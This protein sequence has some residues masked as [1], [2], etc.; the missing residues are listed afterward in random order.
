LN[1]LD[2]LYLGK[3]IDHN[4]LSPD[5]ENLNSFSEKLVET[6]SFLKIKSDNQKENPFKSNQH[7]ENNEKSVKSKNSEKE[8]NFDLQMNNNENQDPNF[9]QIFP[10]NQEMIHSK[11]IILEEEKIISQKQIE[12]NKIN[13]LLEAEGFKKKSLKSPKKLQ[14]YGSMLDVGQKPKKEY[15]MK[16]PNNLRNLDLLFNDYK[17]IDPKK[18]IPL[19]NPI[20]KS[21]TEALELSEKKNEAQKNFIKNENIKSFYDFNRYESFLNEVT[22]KNSSMQNLPPDS[23]K[24]PSS[25]EDF[26]LKFSHLKNELETLSQKIN[27]VVVP[28]PQENQEKEENS[29]ENQDDLLIASLKNLEEDNEKPK[30]YE[31]I[32]QSNQDLNKKQKSNNDRD[33]R[34]PTQR[35]NKGHENENM[36]YSLR[37]LNMR[38][39]EKEKYE[40]TFSLQESSFLKNMNHEREEKSKFQADIHEFERNKQ[41]N[42]KLFIVHGLIESFLNVIDYDK[43]ILTETLKVVDFM[44]ES[45]KVE[46]TQSIKDEKIYETEEKIEI[47]LEENEKEDLKKENSFIDVHQASPKNVENQDITPNNIQSGLKMNRPPDI[48]S[49]IN[50]SK[51]I[52]KTSLEFE[53]KKNYSLSLEKDFDHIDI[54]DLKEDWLKQKNKPPKIIINEVRPNPENL[55]S[56]QRLNVLE[57]ETKDLS[58]KKKLSDFKSLNFQKEDETESNLIHSLKNFT[59]NEP[60]GNIL[61][62]KVLEKIFPTNY[63]EYENKEAP[64]KPTS[65]TD[66][67]LKNIK[68][69]YEENQKNLENLN[70]DKNDHEKKGEVKSL[71]N[72]DSFDYK[73][74]EIFRSFS[75]RTIDNNDQSKISKRSIEPKVSYFQKTK[76]QN[77][78]PENNQILENSQFLKSNT[79]LEEKNSVV[80]VHNNET[81]QENLHEKLSLNE[82]NNED[83]GIVNKEFHKQVVL[84]DF[85]VY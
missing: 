5:S 41:E 26:K 80:D 46:K 34:E 67:D 83:Q 81:S 12:E 70:N 72:C 54:K 75:L 30:S 23:T 22:N 40:K 9:N 27:I 76:E 66:N 47:K 56:E 62:K 51:L 52:T 78:N 15:L 33:M 29:E 79:V 7:I 18:I 84:K 82:K 17:H 65:K 21:K 71:R 45:K 2:K 13:E 55:K 10:D 20:K 16:D 19:E 64:E 58:F 53:L 6:G 48:L 43:N 39:K 35:D 61:E 85:Q 11:E 69:L 77:N 14:N 57:N 73:S 74:N 31:K 25:K 68:D 1:F 28:P 4:F 50:S 44:D 24:K 60:E 8:D 32:Y 36:K 37:D 49:R 3:P 42:E 63:L 38:S 59:Q